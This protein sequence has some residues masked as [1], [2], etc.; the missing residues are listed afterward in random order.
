[1]H[2]LTPFKNG[3]NSLHD[4]LVLILERMTW[5]GVVVAAAAIAGV[6]AGWRMAVLAASAHLL[7]H[8]G[9]DIEEGP[10][11]WTPSNRVR[12]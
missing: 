9:V 7:E 4:Q 3:V 6:A 11:R 5:F 12:A 1:M 2:F 10:N 8:I